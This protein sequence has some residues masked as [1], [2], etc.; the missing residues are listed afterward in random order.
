MRNQYT[1]LLALILLFQGQVLLAQFDKQNYEQ[2]YQDRKDTLFNY[3]AEEYAFNSPGRNNQN[4]AV[5]DPEKYAW[6]AVIARIDRYGINDSVVNQRIEDFRVNEPFHFTMV[7]LAKIMAAYPNIPKLQQHRDTY[8]TKVFA[9]DDSYNGLTVEGTENHLHMTKTSAYIFAEIAYSIDST[10]YPKSGP[11]K[12][13]LKD[14][15][16]Y[17][18]KRLYEVGNS[19]W[20][21][22]NYGIFNLQGWLNLYDY[23]QDQEVRKVARAVLDYYSLEIALHYHKG[24]TAG[25]ESRGNESLRPVGTNTDYTGWL[26]FGQQR[27]PAFSGNGPAYSAYPAASS[28]RPRK[29]V[30][31][32]AT[33]A[34]QFLGDYKWGRP[35]YLLDEA[36]FIRNQTYLEEHFSLGSGIIPYMGYTGGDYQYVGWK[37]A[38][39]GNLGMVHTLTGNGRYYSQKRG[40]GL[41]P[42][43]QLVQDENVLIMMTRANPNDSLKNETIQSTINTWQTKWQ[44]DFDQRFPNDNKPNPIKDILGAFTDDPARAYISFPKAIPHTFSNNTLFLDLD[45]AYVA[46]HSL[47]RNQPSSPASFSGKRDFTEDTATLGSLCGFVLEVAN[48]TDFTDFTDFQNQVGNNTAL[49]KTGYAQDSIRY[50]ALDGRSISAVYVDT[51]SNPREP[52]YDWGYGPTTQQVIP[53]S[54]PFIQPNWTSGAGYGRIPRW[55]V[56]GVEQKLDTAWP[57]FQGPN[58]QLHNSKLEV[59]YDTSMY[60]IDYTG[61]IPIFSDP[62]VLAIQQLR[63]GK[64]EDLLVYPNP[65][66][67]NV[68]V[69][70]PQSY[71]AANQVELFI[72]DIKG[73]EVFNRVVETD[74]NAQFSFNGQS[75]KA[76]IYILRVQVGKKS[77]ST[78]IVK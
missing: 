50:T 17:Y 48:A 32:L 21:S 56:D 25:P 24:V 43:T 44:N 65:F 34:S 33:K 13:Q 55:Y 78:K 42:Y 18:G 19:E 77:F 11:W 10:Q 49:D 52:L 67:Q 22:S 20:N 6:P 70:M 58:L 35:T 74:A 23:A 59:V 9:R 54:P 47:G 12:R 75:L 3:L 5:P 27:P 31:M 62:D 4:T 57:V 46:L 16:L 40:R 61:R 69:Q 76:G 15:I 68:N 45:S 64:K 39:S 29:E 37:L 71:S 60:G 53:K 72:Y 41:D 36:S 38:V 73:R 14:W 30:I 63:T 2:G 28:Y 26:W 7:G 51:L 8:L 66:T 1:K